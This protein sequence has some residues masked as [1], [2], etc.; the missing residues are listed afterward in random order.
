MPS[1]E[2]LRF[3]L[4][5]LLGKLRLVPQLS[6]WKQPH[7]RPNGH[8][9]Q[10]A[11]PQ[12]ILGNQDYVDLEANK[13]IILTSEHQHQTPVKRHQQNNHGLKRMIN[14]DQVGT[15]LW[16]TDQHKPTQNTPHKS[17]CW[18]L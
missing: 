16:D 4:S 8:P 12:L 6:C 1:A 11:I 3:A 17:S 15:Y 2:R 5:P 9:N 13:R 10:V 7:P 14:S 18:T